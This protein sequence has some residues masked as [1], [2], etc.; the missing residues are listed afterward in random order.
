MILDPARA[1]NGLEFLLLTDIV[2]FSTF[3]EANKKLHDTNDDL[4][5]ALEV[6][7]FC[8]YKLSD[9]KNGRKDTY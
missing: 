6:K 5:A 7:C 8:Y 3:S 2:V 4:R 9:I 1:H